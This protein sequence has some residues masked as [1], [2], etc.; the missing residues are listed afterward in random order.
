MQVNHSQSLSVPPVKVWIHARC[1]GEVLAAHCSCMAGNGEACS[2]VAALLFY[3]ECVTRARE[4]RSCTDSDNAWLP[5]HVRKIEARPVA[6]MDFSSATMK[7]RRLD[8]N[9]C[10]P[11]QLPA[12]K[13]APPPTEDEWSAF[14]GAVTASGLRPAVLSTK[15]EYS[16]L[17]MPAVRTC[18]GA[19]LRLLYDQAAVKKSYEELIEQ[20]EKTFSSLEI[21][22][23]AI[24]SIEQRTRNQ[25]KSTNWFAYRTGRITASTL[26]DVCHTQF[27]APSKSLIN[28][29][30]FPNS[31]ELSVP[32]VKYGREKE[33]VALGQYKTLMAAGHNHVQFEEAGLFISKEH[34]YLAATP[35]M[36]VE[37]SCCGAGVVE[38][39]CPWKGRDGRLTDLLK[40]KNSC[41][42][43][44]DGELQLKPTHRYYHQIQA[45]MYVCKK[46]YADFVLWNAQEINV[47][48][49]QRDDNFISP[50]VSTARR[51]FKAVLLPE[52][53]ARWF[54]EGNNIQDT[55]DGVASNDR[56]PGESTAPLV[57]LAS[58][59]VVHDNQ[60]PQGSDAC[61]TAADTFCVCGG[62]D[63]G[64]MIACDNENC[65]LKWF[66]YSCV[67][68]KRAP[69][70]KLWFCS[71]C[72]DA[73]KKK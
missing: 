11:P 29:I 52:L 20:C 12:K 61:N 64:R 49:I 1:D 22:E 17:Y 70:S 9:L 59:A 14:F 53:V 54:S 58:N 6:E 23:A 34:L 13:S 44:V 15:P 38:V 46:N 55:V 48:R 43:E 72:R 65:R 45:Q 18:N 30:C 67:G 31:K 57:P 66:H 51:F 21:N 62:P 16:S 10:V 56:L 25:A 4:E 36:L 71:S 26:Y 69:K 41:V 37:C 40:D 27:Y 35:D 19:D 42:R 32:S 63:E 5:A 28:R 73:A 8:E 2:H 3:I 7:K 68:L 47:Q 33:A 24:N 39:K 60:D 50:L